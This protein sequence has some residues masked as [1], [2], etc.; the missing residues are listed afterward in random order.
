MG[1]LC[2]RLQ[3][4]LTPVSSKKTKLELTW[5]GKEHRPKLEPRILLE[6]ADKSYHAAHRVTD[7]DLFENRL[8]HGD[9]GGNRVENLEWATPSENQ[10]RQHTYKSHMTIKEM[11]QEINRLKEIVKTTR[12]DSK[13]TKSQIDRIREDVYSV[14]FKVSMMDQKL[15]AERDDAWRYMNECLTELYIIYLRGKMDR[16]KKQK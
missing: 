9:R 1:G 5:I 12:A 16:P 14:Y 10:F 3:E 11:K 4:L 6:E 7:R 2:L 8:I 15:D 13:K